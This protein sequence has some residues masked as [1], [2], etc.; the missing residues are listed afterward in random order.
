MPVEPSHAGETVGDALDEPQSGE[1][2]DGA[3]RRLGEG[4]GIR[5]DQRGKQGE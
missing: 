1:G 5:D 2:A 4:V 3:V